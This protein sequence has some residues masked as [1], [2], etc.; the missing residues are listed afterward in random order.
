MSDRAVGRE[1]TAG[2]RQRAARLAAVAL[3]FAG[4]AFAQGVEQVH[5][6]EGPQLYNASV[7]GAYY[8]EGLGRGLGLSGLGDSLKADSA[9]GGT[10]SM[11]WASYRERSNFAIT[12]SP[13]FVMSARRPEWNS[14]QH[15][16]SANGGRKLSGRWLST[17]GVAASL[18]STAQFIFMPTFYGQ[19]AAVPATFDDLVQG[20]LRNTFNNFELASILTGAPLIESPARSV[21]YGDRMLSAAARAGLTYSVSPRT[22]LTFAAEG[23]RNQF[24][25]AKQD[26]R[27]PHILDRTTMAGVSIGLSHSRSPRTQ[28]GVTASGGRT[29]SRYQDA[30]QTVV[31]AHIG[32]ALTRRWLVQLHGGSGFVEALRQ[33]NRLPTGPQYQVGGNA[34]FKTEAHTFIAGAD[35]TFGDAYGMGSAST[36]TV[37]GAWSWT[38]PGGAW[39]LRA[40]FAQQYYRRGIFGNIDGWQAN[41]GIGRRVSR[42]TSVHLEYMHLSYSQLAGSSARTNQSAVRAVFAW[43]AAPVRTLVRQE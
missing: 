5:R 18:S 1:K 16:L 19:V 25:S 31:D 34:A 42:H 36:V 20:V 39:G 13:G 30:Y 35:R 43:S 29:F 3:A 23:G 27:Q 4:A 28:I 14:F 33:T 2:G 21:L 26:V 38:Q 10:A 8:S 17:F 22:S 7:F 24:I 32:H 6:R 40:S 15:S 9:V 37:R 11:G 12:Y 41:A